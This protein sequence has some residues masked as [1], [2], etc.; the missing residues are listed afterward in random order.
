M[1]HVKITNTTL[2]RVRKTSVNTTKEQGGSRR[3]HGRLGSTRCRSRTWSCGMEPGVCHAL[4]AATALVAEAL[5]RTGCFE[6][7]VPQGTFLVWAKM[8]AALP[9]SSEEVVQR[10]RDDAQVSVVPG[11]EKFFGPA[12]SG[13]IRISCAT[14]MERL[15]ESME[16]ISA[17]CKTVG[18]KLPR[19]GS[20]T[21]SVGRLERQKSIK[22]SVQ[23]PTLQRFVDS[24][25]R[26][27]LPSLPRH[28]AMA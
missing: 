5:N 16:R 22:G 13:Y 17:W 27:V 10:L 21:V 2:P 3:V 14:D 18:H 26:R 23:K 25:I 9:M 15:Y 12:A 19:Q 7:V 6:C 1:S 24:I 28:T 8:T 20:L 4:P 11:S